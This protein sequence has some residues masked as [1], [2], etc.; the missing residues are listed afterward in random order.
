MSIL[1]IPDTRKTHTHT[2]VNTTRNSYSTKNTTQ[3]G[4]FGRGFRGIAPF[5]TLIWKRHYQKWRDVISDQTY[6]PIKHKNR[7]IKRKRKTSF[8]WSGK[9]RHINLDRVRNKCILSNK[10]SKAKGIWTEKNDWVTNRKIGYAPATFTTWVNV[11]YRTDIT[12]LLAGNVINI[13]N[14]HEMQIISTERGY[15]HEMKI[16]PQ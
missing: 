14:I 3:C 10:T 9:R 8:Y 12:S 7:D 16:L 5:P 15:F 2:H 1:Q 6:T 4:H 11:K 13:Y